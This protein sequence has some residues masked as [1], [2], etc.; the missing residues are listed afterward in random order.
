L[1]KKIL[2]VEDSCHLRELLEKILASRGWDPILA[3][4]GREALAELECQ[5]PRVILM[6]M[7]LPDM[8]GFSLAGILKK[9]PVYRNIPILATTGSPDDIARQR[10]L[11]AGCDDFISKPFGI[12]VLQRRLTNLVSAETPKPIVT[13]GLWPM[14]LPSNRERRFERS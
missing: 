12:S 1:S 3:E 10:C 2:V 11:S 8:S 5:I 13:T 6:D 7:R 14:T 9:H 4:N